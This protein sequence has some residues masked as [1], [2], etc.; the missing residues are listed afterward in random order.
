MR[1]PILHLGS[2]LLYSKDLVANSCG[3]DGW[4]M[5]IYVCIYIG[6]YMQ[7][8]LFEIWHG[9]LT[10]LGALLEPSLGRV[11]PLRVELIQAKLELIRKGPLKVVNQG[12]IHEAPHIVAILYCLLHLYS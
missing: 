5:S 8:F 10:Y 4:S 11:I 7:T 3:T 1:M 2:K 12:P 9:S 6:V